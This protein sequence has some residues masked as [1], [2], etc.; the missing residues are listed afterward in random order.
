MPL[1]QNGAGKKLCRAALRNSVWKNKIM[2]V[3]AD[4][5]FGTR[6]KCEPHWPSSLPI[7]HQEKIKY[8]SWRFVLSI[9]RMFPVKD[10]RNGRND[11]ADAKNNPASTLRGQS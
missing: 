4:F 2:P 5:K 8:L 11:C 10:C 6:W 3:I 7:E 9:R 1:Q